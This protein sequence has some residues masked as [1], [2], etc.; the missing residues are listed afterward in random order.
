[1]SAPTPPLNTKPSRLTLDIRQDVLQRVNVEAQRLELTRKEFL[2]QFLSDF[3]DSMDLPPFDMSG[4][5]VQR[6]ELSLPRWK[7]DK[8]QLISADQRRSRG[9]YA[10][11]LIENTFVGGEG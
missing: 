11:T 10:S 9:N 4:G 1:M 6:I 3:I 8:L 2:E 7:C 5:G